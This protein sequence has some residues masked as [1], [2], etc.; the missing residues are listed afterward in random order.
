MKKRIFIKSVT[1]LKAS[2]F[3][4]TVSTRLLVIFVTICKYPLTLN[5]LHSFERQVDYE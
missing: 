1:A 5:N 4:S 3:Y 2:R